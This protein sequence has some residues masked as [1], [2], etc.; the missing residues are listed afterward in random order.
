MNG[1]QDAPAALQAVDGHQIGWNA[2]VAHPVD[3]PD[4]GI[5]MIEIGLNLRMRLFNG[6]TN[7]FNGGVV[8]QSML[9]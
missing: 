1:N 5:D 6:F 4:N 3:H 7:L 2:I 8:F 9:L